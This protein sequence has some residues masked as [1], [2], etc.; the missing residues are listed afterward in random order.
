MIDPYAKLSDSPDGKMGKPHV[1][2]RHSC[3]IFADE[4]IRFLG[5]QRKTPFF[6]YVSFN[7]P[8]DPHTVPEDFPIQ[9]QSRRNSAAAELPSQHPWDNGEMQI[10]DETLLS[11]P[12]TPDQVRSLNAEYY[13]YISYLDLQV[14]RIL[15]ALARLA[16]C[17]EYHRGLHRRF[18]CCS[19]QPR[20]DRQA[21]RL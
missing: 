20:I 19:R 7:A 10:R 13:R 14:G 2:P 4:A 15:D 5:E 3:A 21:E 18:R 6:C 16:V 9:L 12:R 11:W 17:H 1:R 8:H